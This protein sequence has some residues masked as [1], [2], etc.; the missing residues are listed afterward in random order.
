MSSY[1]L[2]V[3]PCARCALLLTSH[4]LM[5]QDD[6][7]HLHTLRVVTIFL[8]PLQLEDLRQLRDYGIENGSVL[9]HVPS[10]SSASSSSSSS[11]SSDLTTNGT[12]GAAAPIDYAAVARLLAAAH[13]HTL[14]GRT[15]DPAD[16]SAQPESS[17]W[18]T[19]WTGETRSRGRRGCAAMM[20]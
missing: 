13:A 3:R 17:D 1:T 5:G 4:D 7:C 6:T 16:Y 15:G 8:H 2:L 20:N 19:E 12:G 10:S 9:A 11:S 14:G 18:T